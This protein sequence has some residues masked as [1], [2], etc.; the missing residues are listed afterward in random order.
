[1]NGARGTCKKEN[2]LA[3]ASRRATQAPNPS[4]GRSLLLT[5]PVVPPPERALGSSRSP[6]GWRRLGISPSLRRFW[7]ARPSE[8]PE[9][10]SPAWDTPAA[11][12]A[13]PPRS[14]AALAGSDGRALWGAGAWEERRP[15][16]GGGG[17]YGFIGSTGGVGSGDW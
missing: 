5:S 9:G 17:G 10:S 11:E 6:C 3:V 15:E 2:A 14:G 7:R 16:Q 1:M 4:R 13:G 12:V 8:I